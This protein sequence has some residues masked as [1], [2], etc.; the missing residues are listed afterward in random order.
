MGKL[1]LPCP[2]GF[3]C[4]SIE[5]CNNTCNS[6]CSLKKTVVE[7]SDSRFSRQE[8]KTHVGRNFFALRPS[9]CSKLYLFD[10]CDIFDIHEHGL[11]DQNVAALLQV[12]FFVMYNAVACTNNSDLGKVATSNS[13][14]VQQQHG[15]NTNTMLQV[16][17]STKRMAKI[18]TKS[19]QT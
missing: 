18:T 14:P 10:Q 8:F 13:L 6:F 17:R 11:P 2:T 3:L 4:N 5:N 1:I 15:L 9:F 7:Q 12:S 19:V 16:N